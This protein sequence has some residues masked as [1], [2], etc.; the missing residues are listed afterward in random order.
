[1]YNSFKEDSTNLILR[2]I[3]AYSCGVGQIDVKIVETTLLKEKK[4]IKLT[5]AGSKRVTLYPSLK[6]TLSLKYKLPEYKIPEGTNYYGKLY[7]NSINDEKEIVK[8]PILIK[9]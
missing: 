2:L 1:M 3:P 5:D 4:E 8:L 9:K 7:F 6:K